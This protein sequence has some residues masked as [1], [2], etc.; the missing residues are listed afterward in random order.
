MFRVLTAFLLA[1][2]TAFPAQG[3]GRFPPDS[4]R[5]IKVLPGTMSPREVVAVMQ[6]Y[7]RALGVRCPHCHVGQEGQPLTT[8]DFASDEPRNKLVARDMIRM[9]ETINQQTLA[10]IPDRPDSTLQVTCNTCHRGVSRPVPLEQLVVQ[11]VRRAGIDSAVRTYRAL[12]ERYYGSD[13]Y[14]FGERSLVRAATT[15]SQAREFDAALAL[16]TL[17]NEFYPG[18]SDLM[19]ATGDVQ[20]V[21]GDTAAAIRSYREALAREPGSQA[22]RQRLT[23]LG[24]QP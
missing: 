11:A 10:R 19:V 4:L 2:L 14:D 6:G 5:N 1:A 16:L 13:A 9:V 8:F 23:Q 18:G 24:Q 20:R 12:R 7:T 22:A 17:D 21:R 3:Q 15:L